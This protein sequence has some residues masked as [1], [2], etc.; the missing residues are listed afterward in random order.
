MMVRCGRIKGH[1]TFAEDRPFRVDRN[2]FVYR[3]D[4]A[5]SFAELDSAH[6]LL[7]WKGHSVLAMG[8]LGI[9]NFQFAWFGDRVIAP[10]ISGRDAS[11]SQN[12]VCRY[13]VLAFPDSLP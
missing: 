8:W 13:F 2:F 7:W 12:V 11:G 5:S 1:S 6:K 4:I 10:G 9:F 3:I